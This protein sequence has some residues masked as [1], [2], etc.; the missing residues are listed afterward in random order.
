MDKQSF[1]DRTEKPRL[2]DRNRDRETRKETDAQRDRNK[3]RTETDR[4]RNLKTQ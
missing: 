1:K 3:D 4:F 2:K